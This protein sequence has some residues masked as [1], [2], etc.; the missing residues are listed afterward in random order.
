M[1]SF[2]RVAGFLTAGSTKRGSIS[3]LSKGSSCRHQVV[4]GVFGDGDLV[5]L[6]EGSLE[7]FFEVMGAVGVLCSLV[8]CP[9]ELCRDCSEFGFVLLHS[10]F[11]ITQALI[12]DARVVVVGF[13]TCEC[14]SLVEFL[15]R[16]S[17][18]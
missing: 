16:G 11:K 13:D 3:A 12:A 9:V 1:H 17:S 6:R 14:E 10:E 2:I 7:L 15:R 18:R 5:V 8:E 4:L